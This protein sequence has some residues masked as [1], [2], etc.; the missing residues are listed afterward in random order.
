[1]DPKVCVI[2][3]VVVDVTLPSGQ[4]GYKLR[5]GGIFHA[6]RALWALDIPYGLL[7]IAPT[8]LHQQI[9][10]NAR[11][12]GADYALPIGVVEGCPNVMLI[13]KPQEY[14]AQEYQY[15]LRDECRSRLE[16][17]VIEEFVASNQ[18]TDIIIFP[19]SF[20]L[21]A[22]LQ[23]LSGGS[24]NVHVD[25]NTG[26][27]DLA[28][29]SALGRPVTTLIS[30]TSTQLFLMAFG[31]D[32]ERFFTEALLY[33]DAA[34][35][36]ENRGGSRFVSRQHD[37]PV[38]VPAQP[39]A[40]VH[41][42]GVGDCYNA[43]FAVLRHNHPN[44]V[45]LRFASCLAAEYAATTYPED[46]KAAVRGWLQLPP[47][48]IAQ[49][50]GI[51]VPWETRQEINIYL[52]APD[53]DFVDTRPL[54]ELAAALTYHNFRPRR[55]VR[56]NGQMEPGA[57]KERRR[58]LLAADLQLL[59]DCQVLVAVLL[60]NDPGTLI[61]LGMAVERGIPVIVY[62]PYRKADNLFLTELPVA[63]SSELDVIVTAV[64]TQVSNLRQNP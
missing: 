28:V 16:S 30:S 14:G 58:F 44:D 33:A 27:S 26:V 63:I 51:V 40:V 1:M 43:A 36:K 55:P 54:D 64:F 42:V 18:P 62:D 52:A 53:F 6:A 57:T 13:G 20:D 34:L 31:G 37:H 35:L 60:Y 24:A 50:S 32:P 8:Y 59:S 5:M 49:L 19:G 25:F 15:L 12:Y 45:A 9:E 39:R 23:E 29:L 46:F 48:E 22:V 56:E 11:A 2:G 4:E 3:E 41:S 10:Q 17:G 21:E 47:S 61:E 38:H 7:H